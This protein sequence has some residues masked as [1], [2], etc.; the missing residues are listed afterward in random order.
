MAEPVD[1]RDL[2]RPSRLLR[3]VTRFQHQLEQSIA[4]VERFAAAP[5]VTLGRPAMACL[6]EI[7]LPGAAADRRPAA[8]AFEQ[9]DDIEDQLTVYRETS[10][11]S[12]INRAAGGAPVVVE[13]E[14]F[15]L[16]ERCRELAV[17]TAGAFDITAGPLVSLWNAARR[18]GRPPDDAAVAEA[19]RRVGMDKVELRPDTRSVRLSLPGMALNF[20]SIGKGYAL[21]QV[22]ARLAA[23]GVGAALTSAGH[24][25]MR[26]LEP[27]P[28]DDA[29][30]VDIADPSNPDRMLAAVRLARRA[31]S[32]SGSSFQ[33]F[34]FQGQRLGHILD[35]RTGWPVEGMLQATVLAPDA[36]LAEAL[37]TAFFVHGPDWTADW[38]D[39]HPEIGALLVP[40]PAPGEPVTPLAFGD[41]ALRP[42]RQMRDE[43]PA[44][45]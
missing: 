38:C 36:A 41:I 24:S 20:A 2:F 39:R 5:V 44:D 28:W 17:R 19:L 32:T 27:P 23:A 29:W 18:A 31:L 3:A 33:G 15:H 9:I 6:F 4:R 35:P 7:Q 21:D 10:V 13:P 42:A 16:L 37:S 11:V 14:L 43:S 25:S 22:C 34:D 12:A 45:P 40:Q 1:R 30:Q 8:L 26:A